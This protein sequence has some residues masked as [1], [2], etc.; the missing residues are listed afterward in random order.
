M[1]PPLLENRLCYRP[2]STSLPNSLRSLQYPFYMTRASSAGQGLDGIETC[3]ILRLTYDSL[4]VGETEI[5]LRLRSTPVLPT[6]DGAAL[7]MQGDW[8]PFDTCLSKDW[9]QPLAAL[10]FATLQYDAAATKSFT[11]AD[12]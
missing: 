2:L 6:S 1:T 4:I 9:L 10:L 8:H 5:K 12:A 7:I 11:R 3:P